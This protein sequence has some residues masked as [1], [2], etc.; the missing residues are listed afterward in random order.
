[1]AP[2]GQP[3]LVP[4]HAPVLGGVLVCVLVSHVLSRVRGVLKRDG[5]R[6]F[7]GSCPGFSLG[8]RGMASAVATLLW[9][10]SSTLLFAQPLYVWAAR[11]GRAVRVSLARKL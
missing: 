4:V 8:H 3:V 5:G 1:M 7:S 9:T 6:Q 10:S 2:K 11:H